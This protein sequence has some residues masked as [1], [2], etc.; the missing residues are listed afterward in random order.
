MSNISKTLND[1]LGIDI[2]K[3]IQDVDDEVN[4][5]DEKEV[6]K[7]NERKE[8]V[9]KLKQD[10]KDA[11]SMNNKQW[12]EALLKNSA[13][14]IAITQEI[15]SQEIEDDPISRNVTAQSE[16]SNALANT[17]KSVMDIDFEEQKIAISKEKNNLRRMDIDNKSGPILDAQGKSVIGI[18]TNTDILKLIKQG[19][20][21]N[22]PQ[23]EE[24]ASTE[25][26][27]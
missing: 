2:D 22:K 26:E 16:L 12:S 5:L 19:I 6:E 11:R 27:E 25:P 18:G 9:N 21:P 14:K 20:D 15:F 13:E 17:I 24:N 7:Y 3:V 1:A 8:I 23:G 4:V 10:L